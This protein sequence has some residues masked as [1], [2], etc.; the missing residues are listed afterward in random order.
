MK[1]ASLLLVITLV[2]QSGA[3][4]VTPSSYPQS[5]Q[6]PS[7]QITQVEKIKADVQKHGTGKKSRVKVT[8][9][10]KTQIKGSISQIEDSSFSITDT[11]AGG[12]KSISYA[13]VERI[14][15]AGLSKGA[16]IAIGV[17]VGVAVAFTVFSIWL[18]VHLS[19]Q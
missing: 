15:G 6:T 14:Q 16:K 4:A 9:R 12:T 7:Q 19:H 11:K 17:G 2:A 3:V 5:A 18:N 8:L 13:D 1:S 10:D